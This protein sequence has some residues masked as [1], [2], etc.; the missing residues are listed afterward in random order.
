LFFAKE[1]EAL[2]S[3]YSRMFSPSKWNHPRWSGVDHS[4]GFF[5][6]FFF[7]FCDVATQVIDPSSTREISQ[8]WLRVREE[9]RKSLKNHHAIFWQP[10]GTYCLNMVIFR[11]FFPMKSSDFGAFFF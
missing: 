2:L 10:D 7:N 6:F 8:I 1:N 9:S 4:E 3:E 11:I 5:F